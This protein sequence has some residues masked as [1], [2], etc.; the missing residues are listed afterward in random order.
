[1][2]VEFELPDEIAEA[3]GSADLSR[4]ALEALAAEGY[5]TRKLG[6]GQVRRILGFS[7]PMQV[8]EFLAQRDIPLNYGIEDLE[9][10]IA[11]NERLFGKR[12]M[13]AKRSA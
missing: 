8:H 2:R 10:D 7:T 13:Q 3:L 6:N 5:R 1:M 12:R 11:T 9:Q 4:A